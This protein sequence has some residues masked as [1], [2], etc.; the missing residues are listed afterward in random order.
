LIILAKRFTENDVLLAMELYKINRK[1]YLVRTQI[2][3]DIVN[4][5][6]DK[7]YSPD[8]TM[9]EARD[10]CERTITQAFNKY[11]K[12]VKED[13]INYFKDRIFLVSGILENSAKWD[14]EKLQEQ[15][16]NDLPEL[17]RD[18]LAISLTGYSRD[19]IS[20]K[21]N[22]FQKQIDG[23]A[24]LSAFGAGFPIPGLSAVIDIGILLTMALKIYNSFGLNSE[25]IAAMAG[26]AALS[27][28]IIALLHSATQAISKEYIIKLLGKYAANNVVEETVK[29]I[30]IVGT[31]IAVTL[32]FTVTKAAAQ[33]ILNGLYD[34]SIKLAE[35]LINDAKK[36]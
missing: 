17:Q 25:N 32:S 14:F 24:L 11:F 31:A 4:N 1:F 15:L 19:L 28:R 2:D 21:Y 22:A 35:E 27:N 23:Y 30:P 26:K 13:E 6:R 36:N 20:K 5:G 3:M 34:V 16:L 18:A 8:E 10:Y 29:Y 9:K 33:D 7:N 12:N